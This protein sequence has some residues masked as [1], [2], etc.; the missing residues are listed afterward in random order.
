[1]MTPAVQHLY[2]ARAVVDMR[3]S[4]DGLISL[5]LG[6]LGRDPMSGEGFLFVG[7]NRRMLKL[8]VWDGDGF[9]ILMK[10][11]AK[12]RFVLPEPALAR[13][14]SQ[15]VRL[16]AAAWGALLSGVELAVRRRSP[17]YCP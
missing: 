12:G 16:D 9:W 7:R 1:M 17:R 4:F 2:L 14:A 8:L 10:R 13:D 5:T 6:Q 11:L 15:C 3:K